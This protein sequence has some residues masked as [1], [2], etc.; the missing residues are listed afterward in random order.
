MPGKVTTKQ[1]ALSILKARREEMKL[2]LHY[3]DETD[4]AAWTIEK[5]ANERI[6]VLDKQIQEIENPITIKES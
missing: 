1:L 5:Y 4:I 6:K 2:L 3:V